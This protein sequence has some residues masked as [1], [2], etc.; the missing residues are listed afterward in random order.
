MIAGQSEAGWEVQMRS[1]PADAAC[2]PPQAAGD[3]GVVV[4]PK[5]L[6]PVDWPW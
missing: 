3:Y 4:L 1:Q 6:N 5:M 2:S